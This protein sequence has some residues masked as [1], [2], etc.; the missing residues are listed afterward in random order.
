MEPGFSNPAEVTPTGTATSYQGSY[1]TAVDGTTTASTSGTLINT[2]DGV[3]DGDSVTATTI[4]STGAAAEK[5]NDP[6]RPEL[7]NFALGSLLASGGEGTVAGQYFE[8]SDGYMVIESE[9]QALSTG[10]TDATAGADASGS[11]K[12]SATVDYT[13][14]GQS[15]P[16]TLGVTNA[17]TAAA[18]DVDG[19]TTVDNPSTAF[20]EAVA[21]G[22]MGW[23]DS[24]TAGQAF[25]AF[26]NLDSE[27]GA[28]RYGDQANNGLPTGA[29]DAAGT[30]ELDFVYR[31][32]APATVFSFV[33]NVNGSTDAEAAVTQGNG[34]VTAQGAK[35]ALGTAGTQNDIPTGTLA[36]VA[37]N[38]LMGGVTPNGGQAL[39]DGECKGHAVNP[40]VLGEDEP[41]DPDPAMAITTQN[42]A[43]SASMGSSSLVNAE[44]TATG[45]ADEYENGDRL[46]A[47]A[48]AYAA[49]YD[50][51]DNNPFVSS[52][53]ADVTEPF[54]IVA[55]G[56]FVGADTG[57]DGQADNTAATATVL[58]MF[59]IASTPSLNG[60]MN[61]G[62]SSAD[63]AQDDDLVFQRASSAGA[64]SVT[65][66]NLY[67]ALAL[68]LMSYD[69]DGTTTS[70]Y[71][72]IF[73]GFQPNLD[74]FAIGFILGGGE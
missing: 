74:H 57:P 13:F 23:T 28:T 11:S 70:P 8:T 36:F 54:A 65:G 1:A 52:R 38:V 45:V 69:F 4:G 46:L 24:N 61:N 67:E 47:S 56:S 41:V 44:V 17:D 72:E 33:G 16:E 53:L 51:N 64:D 71:D 59:G 60:A 68:N 40:A 37:G 15:T 58:N 30:L 19:D 2:G 26:L 55:Q 10:S 21:S 66:T 50:E 34:F 22:V 73:Q 3:N 14:D 49:A 20:S 29:A 39:F 7:R 5:E 18:S 35:A 48:V 12:G 43:Y 6:A 63:I 31:P 25:G 62:D 27:T 9:V 32:L 42:D